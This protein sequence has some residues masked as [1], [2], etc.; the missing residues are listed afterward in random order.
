MKSG[1]ATALVLNKW[2]LTSGDDFDLDHERQVVLRKLR[3]RPK[4]LTCSAKTGR[5][6]AR[7][8]VE[9]TSLADRRAHRI[10]TPEVNKFLAEVV[11]LRQPP[12]KQGHRLKLIYGAQIGVDPP[13]FSIQVNSRT[14]VT[15]D[16]AYFIENRL[17]ER[18]G[19]DG[20]PLIVD[21]NERKQRRRADA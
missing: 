16:Y 15:R 20:I 8:L 4:L 11:E 18:Y 1:C 9:A 14:R 3:L 19:L 2:D 5:H 6:I 10:P 21:F 7:L 13:R 17:R 12:A